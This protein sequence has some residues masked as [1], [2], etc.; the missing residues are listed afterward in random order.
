MNGAANRDP[1]QFHD[2]DVLDVE[3]SEPRHLA[4]GAGIHFCVGASL[5][6]LEA[7]IALAAILRRFQRFRVADEQLT[8]NRNLS[9][10]GLKSLH[11]AVDA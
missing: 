1:D 7:P 3:R 11:I 2:P 10:R 8:W 9:L 6:R 5:A 4:F